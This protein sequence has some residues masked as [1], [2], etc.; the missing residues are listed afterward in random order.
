MA[1][2]DWLFQPALKRSAS[3][4]S[5]FPAHSLEEEEDTDSEDEDDY[6]EE[7]DGSTPAVSPYFRS[8]IPSFGSPSPSVEKRPLPSESI[9]L[10]TFLATGE[11]PDYDNSEVTSLH[12]WMCVSYIIM[13]Q[14]FFM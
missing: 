5:V 2:W 14:S 13:P 7:T 6:S 9:P 12:T 1:S 8:T 4:P 10:D 11:A 3:L